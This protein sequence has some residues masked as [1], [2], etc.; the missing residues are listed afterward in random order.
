[1]AERGRAMRYSKPG[2]K[3]KRRHRFA[4]LGKTSRLQPPGAHATVRGDGGQAGRSTRRGATRDPVES[5]RTVVPE[6][7]ELERQEPE[8]EVEAQG[9]SITSVLLRHKIKLK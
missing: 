4:R 5:V 9:H 2:H 3:A 6:R 1:M 8:R 7:E